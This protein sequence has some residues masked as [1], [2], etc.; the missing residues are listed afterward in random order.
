MGAVVAARHLQ[1]GEP[2][3]VKFLHP[4]LAAD[5]ASVERFF[6]EARAASR[7]KSEHVIRVHDVG[8]TEHGLPYIAMELLEGADLGQLVARGPLP[9]PLAVDCVLQASEALAEAHAAGIVHR[10]IKPSNLWLAQRRDGSA[11]VKVLDFGISKLA[12]VEGDAKLTETQAVF[13]SPAYMSP[14]QIRSAKRVDHR[15]DVWALGVVLYELLSAHVPF[16]ADNVA[17]V[18][19]AITADRP[20]P[21]HA[22][23]PEVP[24]ALE[25]LVLACLV[26]DPARRASLNDLA[27]GLRPFATPSGLLSAD[28]IDRADKPSVSLIPPAA[29]PSVPAFAVTETVLD[30]APTRRR[31]MW[32]FGSSIGG[33]VLLGLGALALRA[34]LASTGPVSTPLSRSATAEPSDA[35]SAEHSTFESPPP[36]PVTSATRVGIV[37]SATAS[38]EPPPEPTPQPRPPRIRPVPSASQPVR[39]A[40]PTTAPPIS[41]DRR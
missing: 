8:M 21:I 15:T 27:S 26:K 1:L 23:R 22:F 20:H 36:P 6:R 12:S 16:D 39:P 10:D 24:P 33:I 38:A 7:I 17:G 3:A 34:W 29:R 5:A 13:G 2:L 37:P 4:R 41:E 25:K 30:L 18:L 28:R 35:P 9:I 31:R 14:E 11:L 19:A 32:L 40:P